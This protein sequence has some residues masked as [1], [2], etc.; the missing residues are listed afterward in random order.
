VAW[1][2]KAS[3]VKTDLSFETVQGIG[4]AAGLVDNKSGSIDDDFQGLQ[5]VYRLEDRTPA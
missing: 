4:L 2:K 5:F 3:G 1:P